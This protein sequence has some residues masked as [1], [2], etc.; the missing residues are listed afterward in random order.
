MWK[1]TVCDIADDSYFAGMCEIRTDGFGPK[2]V[3]LLTP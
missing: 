3:Y 2:F 1:V